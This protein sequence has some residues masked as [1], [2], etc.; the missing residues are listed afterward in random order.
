MGNARGNHY[1]RAHATLSPDD[2]EYWQF[3]WNEMGKYDLPAEIDHVLS[4][5]GEEKVFY[6][7]HSMGTT[8][9]YVMGSLRPEYNAKI[10]AQFSLAPVAFMSNLQTPLKF[11]APYVNQIEWVAEF[12]G[13]DEFL[14]NSDLLD[15]VG[16]ALCKDDAITQSLCSNILFLL[17]GYDSQQLN[18]TMIPVIIGHV[19]AGASSKTVI[20]YGQEINSAKFQQYD[21]GKDENLNIY[22]QETPPD[23]DL[24]LVTA[25]VYLHYAEN[26]YLSAVEDVN[27]LA[28]KLPNLQEKIDIPDDKFNH[29]D[30][31]WAIDVKTLVYDKIMSVMESY[32]KGKKREMA[33]ML[34]FVLAAILAVAS[35]RPPAERRLSVGES[36]EVNPEIFMTTPELIQ[37]HGYPVESHVVQTQDGYLLTMHR[38]PYGKGQDPN[39][40]RHAMFL[41]H[42]LLCSSAD[43][44]VMGPGKGLAYILA[45]AGYDVWMG[46][47]RGNTYSKAHVSISTSDEKFWDFSWHEMAI[48]DIPAEIDYVLAH[49]GEDKVFYAGHSMG[50]T[51]FYAMGASRPEYNNKIRAQFSLAPV[52]YLGKIKS[53]IRLL[54]PFIDFIEWIINM[55]GIGEFMPSSD[56][57]DFVGAIACN[58]HAI[59]KDLCDNIF[60]LLCGYDTV[61]LNQT[62]VPV[63]AGH[64]PA[65]T[66]SKTLI[67]Y[68]QEINSGKFRQF[69]YGLFG[70]LKRYGKATPPE[71]DLSLVTAPVYLHYSENDWM[72]SI[73][74]SHIIGQ[75]RQLITL[76]A[77]FSRD[78]SIDFAYIYIYI[79]SV[80]NGFSTYGGVFVRTKEY[81]SE[82][83]SL[84]IVFVA[85][86]IAGVAL[87]A[88]LRDEFLARAEFEAR[89][90]EDDNPDIYLGTPDLIKR[91]GYPVES[92]EVTTED[93][94]ILTMHRI[95]YGLKDNS[96]NRPVVFLQ[97]GLI[98]SSSDWVIMGPEQGF[99]YILAD[100]GY[101][102]WM[103]NARGNRYSR[104]HVS[105]NPDDDDKF[106]DFS[107]HEMGIKDLPAEIDYVIEKTGQSKIF[108]AGHSMGTTMFFVMNSLLPQYNVKF[109]SMHALAPIAFMG[110]V[111]S[112]IKLITPFVDEVSVSC[113]QSL[114]EFFHILYSYKIRREQG[115]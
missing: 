12:F 7:G 64:S 29:L 18:E 47:A 6:V 27:D 80:D 67:H 95:P 58:D 92:H 57:L 36:K 54:A 11:L 66:S 44:V 14:P 87:G 70:N 32:L 111:R 101:D 84:K 35:A 72:A 89:M 96:T 30:F 103:G 23:Y 102:V 42:G 26:D 76:I 109:R 73:E 65:G 112:P 69:D 61:E 28:S 13:I 56:F 113:F 45:D 114:T 107:W 86:A 104:A 71:Y 94:Y 79:Y 43:W 38:I 33:N 3:T 93:G 81:S 39:K 99:A 9:F 1:S 115:K 75:E 59:T 74:Q 49:T 68:A 31:L 8:M 110:K 100:A 77:V 17:C 20:H 5:T 15:M 4:Q 48:H 51:M 106:W 10:R 82:M 2:S 16:A 105:L 19:P 24:S 60:F 108:Y 41:Q 88:T 46:N 50:T 91:R 63:I 53:P 85:L 55:F 83:N 40:P 25:P 97:H 78:K 52:A 90:G 62:M 21:Y 34:A 37:H 98:A 22:G